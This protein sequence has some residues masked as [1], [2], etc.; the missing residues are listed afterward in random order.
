MANED[1]AGGDGEL[2]VDTTTILD[3]DGRV[4]KDSS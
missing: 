2:D 3:E 4:V 1:D